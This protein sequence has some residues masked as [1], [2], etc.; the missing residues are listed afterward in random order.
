M[1]YEYVAYPK[2]V[3]AK[4]DGLVVNRVVQ[5]PKELSDLG[6]GWSESPAGDSDAPK[7]KRPKAT[8]RH[9]RR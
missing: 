9:P 2:M 1:A 5:T 8:R 4:R 7:V 6:A 3:Y